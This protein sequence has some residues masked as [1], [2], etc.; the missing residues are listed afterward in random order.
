MKIESIQIATPRDYFQGQ[1]SAI[2]K[3]T[4]FGPIHVGANNLVGDRQADLQVHGGRDKAVYVYPQEHYSYW[5]QASG[6]LRTARVKLPENPH[7]SFGENLTVSGD[8]EDNVYIGDVFAC[9]E[10]LLQ[11]T[12]AREPCWKLAYKFKQKKLPMWVIS[13]GRTGWYMR[14]LKEGVINTS[15]ALTLVEAGCQQWS[16]MSCNQLYHNKKLNSAKLE[17][18]LTCEGLSDSWRRSFEKRLEI[19]LQLQSSRRN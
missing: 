10:A 6:L 9:G 15:N 18:V 19:A 2:N 13:S 11:V 5:Q 8:T 12:Q 14:V 4:V 3:Q 16:V 7:G 17:S 1:Q